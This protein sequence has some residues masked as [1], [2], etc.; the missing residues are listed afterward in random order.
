MVKDPSKKSSQNQLSVQ[1]NVLPSE[2]DQDPGQSF[3]HAVNLE[4][5]QEKV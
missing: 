4:L 2:Q 1:F 3:P 5:H